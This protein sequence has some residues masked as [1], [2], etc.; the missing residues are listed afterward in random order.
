MVKGGGK[1]AA[2]SHNKKAGLGSSSKELVAKT[3][4][5]KNRS[6]G[7]SSSSSG[8]FPR[9]NTTEPAIE[10]S[11]VGA[12]VHPSWQPW[13]KSVLAG[14][15][16][17]VQMAQAEKSTAASA[18]SSEVQDIESDMLEVHMHAWAQRISDCDVKI[19]DAKD[20]AQRTEAGISL[21]SEVQRLQAVRERSSDELVKAQKKHA[22]AIHAAQAAAEELAMI[23]SHVRDHASPELLTRGKTASRLAL[24]APSPP[25]RLKSLSGSSHEGEKSGWEALV[26]AVRRCLSGQMCFGAPSVLRSSL[27][28]SDVTL[29]HST[30]WS[31]SLVETDPRRQITRFFLPGDDRGPLGYLRAKEM[32]PNSKKRSAFFAVWRPTSYDALRMMMQGGATGKGLNVKGKSAKA[33]LLSGFVPFLQISVDA[34]KKAIG[35]SPKEARIRV[36]Y[37]SADARQQALDAMMLVRDEMLRV[38]GTGE[39]RLPE[40][41]DLDDDDREAVLQSLLWTMADGGKIGLINSY[42]P[43]AFGLDLPERLLW[44]AGVVRQPIEHE[45]GWAT[46]RGSEPAFQELNLHATRDPAIPGVRP[47]TVLWQHDHAR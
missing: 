39:A 19:S 32:M 36:Y 47:K 44:E 38:S 7:A 40:L 46:G 41:G 22:E 26:N 4:A 11:I 35:T 33:G 1:A 9:N 16:V 17:D 24:S 45:E 10:E 6:P 14:A 5:A 23:L 29:N 31:H 43:D 3:P 37:Y 8:S 18:I 30:R 15:K 34:H 12:K 42:S 28:A 20:L 25:P 13:L 2:A 21:V 27:H